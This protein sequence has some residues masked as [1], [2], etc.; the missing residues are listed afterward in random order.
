MSTVDAVLLVQHHDTT[1]DQLGHRRRSLP[2]RAQ[3]A[4]VEDRRAALDA[5]LSEAR[6]RREEVAQRQSRL[7]EEVRFLDGRV[8]EIDKRLYSG[9]VT[10]SRELQAMAAEVEALKARRSSVEDDVLGAMEEQEPL[11]ADVADLEHQREELLAEA[12]RLRVALAEA[13]AAIDAE[14]A[15]EARARSAAARDVPPE[16]LAT[17]E[18]L[19]TKLG[20]VGAARLVGSSCSGCHLTLPLSEVARIKREPPDAVIFCDQCG[21]ILVR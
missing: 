15:E 21:R 1:S 13:E 10:A 20:G 16:L 3:L 2:E 5:R 6:A 11:T 19:R 7:E 9:T 4:A 8:T 18:R 12:D 14:L 17:Y